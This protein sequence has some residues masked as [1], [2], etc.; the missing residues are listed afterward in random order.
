ME[1]NSQGQGEVETWPKLK[2]RLSPS[3][4]VLFNSPT[5]L[6]RCSLISWTGKESSTWSCV[7]SLVFLSHPNL[8]T[9][10]TELYWTRGVPCVVGGIS[11]WRGNMNPRI[12][13]KN[14]HMGFG[15]KTIWENTCTSP[16]TP[17]KATE[18]GRK[19]IKTPNCSSNPGFYLLGKFMSKESRRTEVLSILFQL[20]ALGKVSVALA[21]TRTRSRW[22]GY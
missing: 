21:V 11:M 22:A 20:L 4:V 6:G 19:G 2:S 12:S 13:A 14:N 7:L 17:T 5:P 18:T 8:M 15:M 3:G 16:N 9:G 1:K 10:V